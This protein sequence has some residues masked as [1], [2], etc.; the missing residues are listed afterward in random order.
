MG[1]A[2][3]PHRVL[4]NDGNYLPIF[5]LGTSS[6]DKPVKG[7]TVEAVKIAIEMGYRHFDGAL[8]YGNED[9][10]GEAIRA[11]IADRTVK[12]EDVFYT[13]KVWMTYLSPTLVQKALEKTLKDVQLDYIDLY[14]VH[15]PMGLKPSENELFPSD[16]S[17]KILMDDVDFRETW[18]V[19]ESCKEAGLVRSIGVS[20]FNRAQLEMV[21]KMPNLKYKPVCNQVECHPYFNQNKLLK[22]CQ[23]NNIVLVGY[24]PL[25]KLNYSKFVSPEKP[26]LLNDPELKKIGDKLHKSV[27]QVVLRYQ[28]QRGVV[29]IPKSFNQGRMKQN[30]AIFDFELT[31]EEMKTINGLNKSIRYVT[32]EQKG[33]G[34]KCP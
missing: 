30:M 26:I 12:R 34:P 33:S 11:K 1:S 3:D 32:L 24:S 9:E 18:K 14:L 16:A 19:M 4:L 10:V 5:G 15:W 2:L 25:G 22:Y 7:E 28:V 23:H 17:G 29:V 8:M 21:L 27:A 13:S 6:T 31:N 20:N